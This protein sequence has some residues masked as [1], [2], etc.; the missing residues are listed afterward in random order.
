MQLSF[1]KGLKIVPTGL[2]PDGGLISAARVGKL[3]YR[4]ILWSS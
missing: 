1:A 4:G 3:G 2:G